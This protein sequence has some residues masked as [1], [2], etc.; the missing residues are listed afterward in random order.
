MLINIQ[1]E[2]KKMLSFMFSGAYYQYPMY[3]KLV[4]EETILNYEKVIREKFNLS[5][6]CVRQPKNVGQI[7]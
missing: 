5:K 6:H 2:T 1:T 3:Y 7:I 4:F